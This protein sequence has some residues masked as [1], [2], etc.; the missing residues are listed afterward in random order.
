MR[1]EAVGGTRAPSDPAVADARALLEVEG[2]ET[3]FPFGSRWTTRRGWVRAV[4]G[5]D[6][7]LARGEVLGLVGESGCGKTTLGRSVLRLVEPTAGRVRLDGTD[8]LALRDR[9]LRPLRRRMQIVFQ[10]PYASLSP[11]LQIRRI[12]AEPLLLYRLVSRSGVDDAVAALLSAVGLEPYFMWRYPHEMSGG[13]R[14]RIAIAR[15]LACEPDLLVADEAVSALDVSVQAQVLRILLELQRSRGIAM[16]FIS[17]DLSVVERTADRVA[18][19]YLG[20]IVEEGPTDAVIASPLHPYTQALL[21]AV[22]E[23]DPQGRGER[24]RLR[25]EPPSPTEPIAGCP[26]A[27]RCPEAQAICRR[28]PPPALEPKREGHLAACHLR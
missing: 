16:L 9:E 28:A 2:L 13:Q 21:S 3:W 23:P 14:Q 20:R 11:R 10:D 17:H 6:F 15:A 8:I 12:L 5:V 1:E 18:V 4:D 24:V 25:G 19:M 26:F 27:S 22:P 7:L